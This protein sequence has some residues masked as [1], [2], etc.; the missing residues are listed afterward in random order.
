MSLQLAAALYIYVHY[1]LKKKKRTVVMTCHI[2]RPDL[3]RL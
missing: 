3:L 2:A 1:A